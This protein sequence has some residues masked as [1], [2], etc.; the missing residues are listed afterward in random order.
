MLSSFASINSFTMK[1]N[2]RLV[3]QALIFFILIASGFS[4]LNAGTLKG[5]FINT[6]K[7]NWVYLY[8]HIGPEFV[9]SDSAKLSATQFKFK[10]KDFSRGY[11]RIGISEAKSAL[12]VMGNED[13]EIEGNVLVLPTLTIKGSKENA[14][15]AAFNSFNDNYNKEVG[16][17]DVLAQPIL[18]IRLSDPD[19]F[20]VDIKK[21]QIKLDSLNKEKFS[22]LKNMES[23]N[24][25]LFMGKVAGFLAVPDSVG[26]DNFFK[27]TDFIDSELAAGDMISTK[28]ILYLQKFVNPQLESWQAE[29]ESLL[30]KFA[31][32]S[33]NKEAAYVTLIKIFSQ[34]D[35]DYTKSLASRYKSEM[36]QSKMAVKIYK[37]LPKGAP[38][39]GELAPDIKL[40][41]PNGK[42]MSLSSLKGK[43]VLIDFWASW[44]GPCRR[45]NPNVVRAYD[46]YK[47]KGFTIFSVSLDEDKI[48]WTQAIQKDQLKWDSH[49]SDLKGWQSSA[50]RLYNVKGIPATFLVGK[51]GK[52]VATN[53]RGESLEAKLEE[54]CR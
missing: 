32:G 40:Q 3:S 13:I 11:Y 49:V 23:Q 24:K 51:D 52:I 29:G 9:K 26:K 36:P 45:E 4:S 48:K 21:L 39:A 16:Q 1:V 14:L 33:L 46:K 35:A 30:S 47:D 53:L 54:L 42:E 6:G 12:F 27:N 10:E 25:D 19:K 22:F 18:Q 2:F 20:N 38:V 37:G 28:F 41:N 31:T 43:I 5:K 17:L 8:K 7:A 44:C 34:H 15:L 50:A